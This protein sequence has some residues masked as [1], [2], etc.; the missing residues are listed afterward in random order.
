MFLEGIAMNDESLEAVQ[1]KLKVNQ[2]KLMELKLELET[3]FKIQSRIRMLIGF[4]SGISIACL[5]IGI[6]KYFS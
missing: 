2:V 3:A 5:T 1:E 6:V 4:I